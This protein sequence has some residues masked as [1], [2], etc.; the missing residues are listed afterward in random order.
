ML[1][2]LS[3][4]EPIKKLLPFTPKTMLFKT[5]ELIQQFSNDYDFYGDSY[6]EPIDTEEELIQFLNE[7]QTD[8]SEM[9]GE[10]L[11]LKCINK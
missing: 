7:M 4:E 5:Q 8:V 2:A 9:L 6:T 11:R 10:M 1:K 3:S